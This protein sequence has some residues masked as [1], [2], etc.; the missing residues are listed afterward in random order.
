[1]TNCF[2]LF[3]VKPKEDLE[4][5]KTTCELNLAQLLLLPSDSIQVQ[6]LKQELFRY[7]EEKLAD[8]E[9]S[10]LSSIQDNNYAEGTE[11]YEVEDK[12]SIAN[13][14]KNGQ[15][16]TFQKQDTSDKRSIAS[17]ARN[18]ELHNKRELSNF[19]NDLNEKRNLASLAR[20]YNLPGKRYY[21]FD[22]DYD[23]RNLQSIVRNNGK[24]E[25]LYS[26]EPTLADSGYFYDEYKR[27]LASVARQMSPGARYLVGKR[28]VAALLRQDGY[29]NGEE[30]SEEH[31]VKNKHDEPI[32]ENES[33]KRN[34]ASLKAQIKNQRNYKRDKR[35]VEYDWQT[36]EE[37]PLPVYQNNNV[38]DYEELMKALAGQYPETEKRFLGMCFVIVVIEYF[39]IELRHNIQF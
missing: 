5:P 31:N 10:K 9:L 25:S 18:G 1:M 22:D 29:F 28:N 30:K 35:Q 17:L 27:N 6:A 14:A 2:I 7:L 24:R 23:K 37:Y 20:N 32:T 26:L 39:E 21:D 3:Q 16:P 33:E 19:L 12:R 13:L 8:S 4:Y 11:E 36:N 38:Y 15:L 34:I